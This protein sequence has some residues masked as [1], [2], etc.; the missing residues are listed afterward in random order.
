MAAVFPS[1]VKI[2]TTKTDLV[3]TVLADHVNV[4]QDEVGSIEAALGTGLLS[5]AWSSS[6]S[7]PSTHTTL[8]ARTANVEN[9]AT[10]L[11]TVKAPLASPTLTGTPAA[12]T[13]SAATST[14]QIATTAFST[15]GI[16]THAALTTSHGV[17]GVVVGT[18]DTQTLT[19]K[20]LTTPVIAVITN[21]GSLTLPTTTDTLVGRATTDTLTNK[22]LTSP[23]IATV[24]NSGTLTLPSGPDTLVARTT[25]DTLTNKTLTSP[26]MATIVNSGTLTLPTST[27]TLVGRTTSDTLTNKTISGASNTV[28]NIAQASVTNLTSDLGLKAALASPTLTGTPAAPTAAVNTNTTQVATTAF[29]VGQGYLTTS[30]AGTTYAPLASPTLTGTPSAP[31]ATGGTNTTQLATTAFVTAGVSTHASVTNAVHGLAGTVVGTSDSQTLT[32]KTIDGGSNTL[33]NIPQASVSGLSTT[34]SGLSA[35]YAPLNVTLS[36]QTSSYTLVLTDNA[37]Q[38]EISSGSANVLT[39]PPNSAVAFPI[40]TVITVVQTGTGQTSVAAG[41]GVTVNVTPGLKLRAQWSG[42]ALIKRGTDTWLMS[43]DISA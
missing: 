14:T 39:V 28:S 5:S 13:A 40:G 33:S 26:V 8:A 41:S 27:D 22:T 19:N 37:K 25:T 38:V 21:T 42:A 9:Y 10:S 1:G 6:Y 24:T 18:S 32:N 12:P 43:G 15:T 3:D 35:N 17:S 36:Q 34:I 23:V 2:F 7:T 31:T 11:N 29:V 4:L 30:T 20:T 16:S